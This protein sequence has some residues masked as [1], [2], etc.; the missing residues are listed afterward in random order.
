[1]GRRR[2]F[3]CWPPNV[4]K[5]EKVRPSHPSSSSSSLR[6]FFP[7]PSLPPFLRRDF[8]LFPLFCVCEGK[9][10]SYFFLL[11]SLNC[12]RRDCMGISPKMLQFLKVGRNCLSYVTIIFYIFLV[13]LMH[14]SAGPSN[15]GDPEIFKASLPFSS[16]WERL[17]RRIFIQRFPGFRRWK[18]CTVHAVLIQTVSALSCPQAKDFKRQFWFIRNIFIDL[19]F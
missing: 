4:A 17:R 3:L 13:S 7:L 18:E 11:P 1:M 2:V 10:H 15:R 5:G 12:F 6:R 14:P 8:L 16:P 9:N 19:S